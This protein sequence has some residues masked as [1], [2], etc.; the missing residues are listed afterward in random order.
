MK[1][2]SLSTARAAAPGDGSRTRWGSCSS[3]V[4]GLLLLPA[5]AGAQPPSA[6]APFT[7]VPLT[8]DA[9]RVATGRG[10]DGSARAEPLGADAA[11]GLDAAPNLDVV[12]GPRPLVDARAGR[13]DRQ[14][15]EARGLRQRAVQAHP[16]ADR[17]RRGLALRIARALSDPRLDQRDLVIAR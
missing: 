7:S 15:V 8:R 2:R 17:R 6:P 14:P 5:I 9:S 12:S 13:V 16:G 1:P 4:V 3:L 11:V 10:A